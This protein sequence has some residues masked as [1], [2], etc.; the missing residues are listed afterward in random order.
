[1]SKSLP[2]SRASTSS[3][4]SSAAEAVDAQEDNLPED[5]DAV[6][7]D[8]NDQQIPDDSAVKQPSPAKDLN[9]DAYDRQ[10]ELQ[11]QHAGDEQVPVVDDSAVEQP[12]DVIVDDNEAGQD[13]VEEE[14][15]TE[16]TE[17]VL[18]QIL[19]GHK[20]HLLTQTRC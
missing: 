7:D 11:F 3:R 1:M 10:K 12:T 19:D 16:A 8:G 15:E 17:Q 20:Y 9:S 18:A 2:E 5:A 14:K 13:E 6:E 4:V